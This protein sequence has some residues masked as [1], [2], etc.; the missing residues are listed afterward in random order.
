MIFIAAAGLRAGFAA[1]FLHI[2]SIEII[3]G[4]QKETQTENNCY[5]LK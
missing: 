2:L 1:V 5:D 4:S 3:F